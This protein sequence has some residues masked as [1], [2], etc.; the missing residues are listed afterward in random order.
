MWNDGVA[1][2][3]HEPRGRSGDRI[4]DVEAVRHRIDAIAATTS[5]S[6]SFLALSQYLHRRVAHG[7]EVPREPC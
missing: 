2:L 4:D 1:I 3:S 7:V 5:S 6:S